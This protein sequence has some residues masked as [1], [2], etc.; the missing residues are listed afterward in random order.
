[1]SIVTEMLLL[2]EDDEQVYCMFSDYSNS[3][4]YV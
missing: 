1:M 2:L 3:Q 4:C